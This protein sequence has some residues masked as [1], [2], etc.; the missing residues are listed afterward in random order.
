MTIRLGID[1]GTTRTVVAAQEDGTYPVCTFSREGELKEFIP[2]LAAVK[3]GILYFGWDAADRLNQP[4][5]YVLRSMKRLAGHLRPDDPVDLGPDFSVTLLELVTLFLTHVRQMIVKH[6]TIPL[7]KKEPIEVMVASPANANSN[8]RYITLEGFRKAGF[9]VLGAMNEPSAAAVEFLHRYLRDLGPRSPKRYVAVYDL[10]GGTFDTSVVGIAEQTH[11]V[12]AHQGIG[13]LGGDDFDEIILSLALD[14]M[15]L[16]PETLTPSNAVRLLEECRERK[17][18]L[19]PNTK[20]MI[21]DPGAVFQDQKPAV[22]DTGL[23]YE[24]C[25]PLIERS[26]S[27]LQNLLQNIGETPEDGRSLAAVYLVG[28]SVSFPP[29]SRKLREAYPSKVRIAPLPHASTAIGLSIAGDPRAKISVRESV[30]R[31]FGIWR[32][33]GEDKIFDPIFPKDR[34]VDAGNGRL[35]VTRTYNPVHNIGLLRY[36]ECSSLGKAEEPEGDIALW[37]DVYFPYDPKLRDRKDL[38]KIS[39]EKSPGACSQEVTEAYEYNE[40]GIIRVE[41]ENKTSGY[42]RLFTLGPKSSS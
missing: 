41:I 34:Q 5:T 26:L 21:V 4:D 31:H 19:K 38:P 22:L 33:R 35:R 15:G 7:K 10:G 1:F 40:E 29:V 9:T 39:I 12:V 2:T 20:K 25:G 27:T 17:E 30:S 24:R 6:G 32:E 8:Q 18:G 14:Q 3:D 36:L 11:D 16:G 42:K 23:V 13:Q 28:G 37:Q